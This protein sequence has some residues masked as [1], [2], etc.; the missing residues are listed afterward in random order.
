MSERALLA[1]LALLGLLVGGCGYQAVGYGGLHRADVRT[2][3]VPAVGNATDDPSFA[4]AIGPALIDRLEAATPYRIAS[5]GRADT[6][7]EVRVTG[8]GRN[9]T[10]RQREV[11]TP[12]QAVW[13]VRVDA[14]WRD[15]RTGETLLSLRNLEQTA[16]QYPSLGE[17]TFLPT[18]QAAEAGGGGHRRADGPRVVSLSH[19]ATRTK[20]KH[21]AVRIV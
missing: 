16:A 17:G 13:T 5:A 15:L 10:L 4:E 9:V 11:A 20:A 19:P 21:A 7:L 2:V 18:Q 8:A 3:A 6:L 1:L 12:E 14:D